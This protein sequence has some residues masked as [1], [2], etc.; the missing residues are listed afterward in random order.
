MCGILTLSPSICPLPRSTIG[1]GAYAPLLVFNVL[2]M[3][4]DREIRARFTWERT[5]GPLG[6]WAWPKHNCREE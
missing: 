1:H 4:V 6:R 5:K 3:G 2:G